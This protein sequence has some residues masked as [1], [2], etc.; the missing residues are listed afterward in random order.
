MNVDKIYFVVENNALHPQ[1]SNNSFLL[2][3]LAKIYLVNFS[4]GHIP[5]ITLL[6]GLSRIYLLAHYPTDVIAGVIVG[7]I[8]SVVAYYITK[9]IYFLLLKWQNVKLFNFILDFDLKI[10]K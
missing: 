5:I 4:I 3:P 9:F 7:T 2:F 1:L 10:K 6:M 8:S